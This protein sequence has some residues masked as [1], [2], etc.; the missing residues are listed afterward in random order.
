[1]VAEV[2][3]PNVQDLQQDVIELLGQISDLMSRASSNL[4][5][6]EPDNKYIDFEKQIRNATSKVENM[7]LRMAI[8]APMKAG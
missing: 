8:V 7:E 6:D 1:M 5:S 3:R 4:S 2:V